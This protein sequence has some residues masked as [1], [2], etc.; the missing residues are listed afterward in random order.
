[1]SDNE[2]NGAS[3]T[4]WAE[5]PDGTV[6]VPEF[7]ELPDPALTLPELLANLL[8][9]P[10]HHNTSLARVAHAA[11]YREAE[12][13][14]WKLDSKSNKFQ[15]LEYLVEHVP[16][17]ATLI[18]LDWPK[19]TPEMFSKQKPALLPGFI[20][21]RLNA[22][23]EQEVWATR[24]RAPLR[25]PPAPEGQEESPADSTISGETAPPEEGAEHRR[26]G[27]VPPHTQDDKDR[28][29]PMIEDLRQT[30]NCVLVAEVTER[31][32]KL[33]HDAAPFNGFLRGLVQERIGNIEDVQAANNRA[34]EALSR[35]LRALRSEGEANT[36]ANEARTRAD[37]A[38]TRADAAEAQLSGWRWAAVL[39]PVVTG[40]A[41]WLSGAMSH[42]PSS[43]SNANTPVRSAMVQREVPLDN[44]PPGGEKSRYPTEQHRIAMEE[45]F[46]RQETKQ[47]YRELYDKWVQ[48]PEHF[49]RLLDD[50]L[51]Q[52][53]KKSTSRQLYAD[54]RRD[55]GLTVEALEKKDY[56]AAYN[57]LYSVSGNNINRKLLNLKNY[58]RAR[59]N[60]I[61]VSEAFGL[62]EKATAQQKRTPPVEEE[63][64][65][66]EDAKAYADK[67]CRLLMKYKWD[68]EVPPGVRM[69]IRELKEKPEETVKLLERQFEHDIARSE[70]A[71]KT[72][73]EDLRSITSGIFALQ[74]L[75]VLNGA[76]GLLL[77]TMLQRWTA[78]SHENAYAFD[79]YANAFSNTFIL[80]EK[81][82]RQKAQK[83]PPIN[84]PLPELR[85]NRI[86]PGKATPLTP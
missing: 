9:V 80:M 57:Y 71:Q 60:L 11:I 3:G 86:T 49:L 24:E 41:L 22:Q 74:E 19:L 10:P 55:M 65:P 66:P 1:M 29:P 43:P 27:V 48:N 63:S 36:C 25:Y 79:R 31:I 2:E 37:A 47:K 61:W 30:E 45:D 32:R 4:P 72:A 38:R 28:L 6:Q 33:I 82:Q 54:C 83:P 40:G 67:D 26:R 59:L 15:L 44:R 70:G 35:L 75:G 21:R 34:N 17:L 56:A 42:S 69:R 16:G 5:N 51:A 85:P 46:A 73:Y 78:S 14:D 23:S 84:E 20:G 68:D 62:S 81:I 53:E 13:G 64:I 39:G 58:E 8:N 76:G 77:G 52:D 18:A 50:V 12:T 7:D